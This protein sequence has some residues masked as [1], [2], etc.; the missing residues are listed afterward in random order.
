MVQ[1]TCNPKT[2]EA[3]A[4]EKFKASLGCIVRLC[5]KKQAK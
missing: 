2:C 5:L 1:N 4:A 3:E